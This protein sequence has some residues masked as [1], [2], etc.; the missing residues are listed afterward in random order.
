MTFLDAFYFLVV[1]VSTVGY[2]DISPTTQASRAVIVFFITLSVVLIPMQLN[3]LNVLL[4]ANSTYRY[5]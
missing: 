4:A 1:T 3:E 5:E 2:G